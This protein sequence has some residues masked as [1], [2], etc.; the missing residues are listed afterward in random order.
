MTELFDDEVEFAGS[1]GLEQV[2]AHG[3][4]LLDENPVAAVAQAREILRITPG[5]G[6]ALELLATALRKLGRNAEAADADLIVEASA[7]VKDGQLNPA[8]HL[9]R[10]YLARRPNDPAA[11]RLLAEIAAAVGAVPEAIELLRKALRLAPSYTDARLRLARLLYKR[12]HMA[13][14]IALLDDILT[15]DPENEGARS[16]K[17]ATLERIG[18]YDAALA[19]YDKLLK[20]APERPG[21]WMSYG[22]LL[23]TLG[24]LEDSIAA[25]REAVRLRPNFGHAWWSLANLKT[26]RLGEDDIEAMSAALDQT[27]TDGERRLNLHFA[28]G[29]AYEDSGRYEQSFREYE[30]GN[31]IRQKMLG[32]DPGETSELVRRSKALFTPSFFAARAGSGA[33]APDPIFVVG[34]PRSGSTLIEQILSSHSRIEGTSELPDIPVLRQR[35]EAE[36]ARLGGS[37]FP[38]LLADLDLGELRAFGEEYLENAG[39]HRKTDKPFFVDKLPNNWAHIGLIHL[40]LP[41]ARIIDARRHP[42][43]CC[44][45]NFKQHF[46]QGQGFSYSLEDLGRYYRDY[47]E[48]LRHFDEVLPGRIHRV[49]HE[50]MVEDTEGEIKR[51]L[52]YLE[53]PFEESCLRF[54]ENERAVR[55]PSAEQ[56]RQPINR[57]GMDRWRA[58]EPWLGP[59]KESLGPVLSCYPDVPRA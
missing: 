47:V 7:L 48:L 38:D 58:F 22:H 53:L 34:L 26:V 44:F 17:A 24:R 25:Y 10:P 42:L 56:V 54:Y 23:N 1:A 8:E 4:G 12:N 19:I 2:L 31:R 21:I 9:I 27:E 18:E 32:Y 14:A 40:I 50:N 36:S 52:E 46:A 6:D 41:N 43:G 11:I 3:R 16:S 15:H 55:T 13:E 57:S 20:E 28:L 37:P 39:L 5:Q 59:L 49:F 35:L 51:M 30:Q 33:P 29:K 45:S